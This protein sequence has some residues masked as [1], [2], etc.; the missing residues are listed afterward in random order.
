M[1]NAHTL[2]CLERAIKRSQGE[3]VVGGDW[4]NNKEDLDSFAEAVGGVIVA[5]PIPT[6][7]ACSEV[8]GVTESIIDFFIVSLGMVTKVQGFWFEAII[9]EHVEVGEETG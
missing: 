9:V 2:S 8:A 1:D 3:W 4:N 7:K 6:C 5:P